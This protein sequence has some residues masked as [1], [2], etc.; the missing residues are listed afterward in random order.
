MLT[1]Y[2]V[3]HVEPVKP[4]EDNTLSD[5]LE[6]TQESNSNG[7][8]DGSQG[9]DSGEDDL[10]GVDGKDLSKILSDEVCLSLLY[11]ILLC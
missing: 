11:D 3:L 5:E 4:A 1:K 7:H 10:L 8:S 2:K 9:S 6:Y